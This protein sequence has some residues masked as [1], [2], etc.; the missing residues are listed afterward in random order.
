MSALYKIDQAPCYGLHEDGIERAVVDVV[1]I[2]CGRVWQSPDNVVGCVNVVV[3]PC[4]R[5]WV[6]VMDSG[7]IDIF[8]ESS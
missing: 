5:L 2:G 6:D 1:V 8:A 3:T 4:N 7:L